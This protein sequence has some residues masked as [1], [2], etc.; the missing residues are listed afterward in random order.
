MLPQPDIIAALRPLPYPHELQTYLLDFTAGLT[1]KLNPANGF[2]H[3]PS[4]KNSLFVTERDMNEVL[5]TM[6][7]VFQD[8]GYLKPWELENAVIKKYYPELSA[9]TLFLADQLSA[10]TREPDHLTSFYSKDHVPMMMGLAALYHQATGSP[11]KAIELDLSNM[12]GT[13]ENFAR[14]IALCENRSE[15]SVMR[16]AEMMTDH[17]TLITCNAILKKIALQY[18]TQIF[19][20]VRTGGDEV[21]ILLPGADSVTAELILNDIHE[22]IES[23][24]AAMGQHDHKHSKRPGHQWANGYGAGGTVFDIKADGHAAYSED[25]KNADHAIQQVK[26]QLGL[27]RINN[28]DYDSLKPYASK[29]PARYTD[30]EIAADHLIAVSNAMAELHERLVE[31]NPDPGTIPRLEA[32]A[33]ARSPD[34]FLTLTQIQE[35]FHAHLA[36]IS[37]EEGVHL[38]Q[39]QEKA[40]LIKIKKFPSDDFATGALSARD[41]PP[42]AGAALQV[43][44]DIRARTGYPEK[45]ALLGVS[46]HNLAGLNETLGHELANLTLRHL[47]SR[48]IQSALHKS[49][50]ASENIVLAHMG[51]GEFRAV[52]Q[53]VIPGPEGTIRVITDDE[54][55]T[56]RESIRQNLSAL[57]AGSIRDFLTANGY[58]GTRLTLPEKF[59]DIPNPRMEL[60]PSENGLVATIATARY[61]TDQHQD[62]AARRKGGVLNHHLGEILQSEISARRER[63]R[64]TASPA[65]RNPGPANRP[66]A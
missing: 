27:R 12:R 48:V 13:N 49:G 33:H 17:V 54:L 42:M 55:L 7:S 5:D 21:R 63:E 15:K 59:S 8:Q 11:V 9:R 35:E 34:H 2:A 41:F 24:T 16:D 65:P 22:E 40:L 31:D 19:M 60:R 51:G 57:N 32:I 58:D 36:D 10:E 4:G 47:A 52:I 28:P 46:F 6:R 45:P 44:E 50:L 64:N 29:N 61:D 3:K 30:P 20:P 56:I 26:E 23:V 14:L 38:T 66:D 37:K 18:P 43:I 53:P 1:G 25:I 62:I 39:D